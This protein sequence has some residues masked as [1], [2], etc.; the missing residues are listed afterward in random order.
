MLK[1]K[2]CILFF[3]KISN[4]YLKLGILE[5]LVWWNNLNQFLKFW[6]GEGE[7]P[8]NIKEVRRPW[9]K[10]GSQILNFWSISISKCNLWVWYACRKF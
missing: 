10:R 4:V 1:L 9:L 8:K 2:I 7:D 5:G 3:R 6:K